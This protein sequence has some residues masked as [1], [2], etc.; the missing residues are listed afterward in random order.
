MRRDPVTSST[1]RSIGYDADTAI[2][3]VEFANGGIYRFF[4]IPSSLHRRLLSAESK[5]TFFHLNIRDR[6]PFAR[7]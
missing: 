5:G 6:F 4:A 3:E 1:L 7:V 2:M